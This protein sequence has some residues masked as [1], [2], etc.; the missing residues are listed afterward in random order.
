MTQKMHQ[1]LRSS[2]INILLSN[3]RKL[4]SKKWLCGVPRLDM[5][6]RTKQKLNIL[7]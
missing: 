3:R 5:L 2:Y 1:K 6:F 4:N 7:N